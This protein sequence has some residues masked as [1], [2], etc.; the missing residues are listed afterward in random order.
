MEDRP[1]S[2]FWH[3]H[4]SDLLTPSG[5]DFRP[6]LTM[7]RRREHPGPAWRGGKTFALANGP[8]SVAFEPGI[9]LDRTGEW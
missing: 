2:A 5:D 4:W 9:G 7:S 1:G 6:A 3:T 8:A